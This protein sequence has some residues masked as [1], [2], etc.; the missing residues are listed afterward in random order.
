MLFLEGPRGVGFSYQNKTV[1]PDNTYS[2]EATIKD[3][4]L[5]LKDFFD[6]YPEYQDREFYV[7]AESYGG[8]YGPTLT[9]ALIQEIQNGQFPHLNLVGMG[10]LTFE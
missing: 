2:D 9:R 7:F 8:V 1:D 3:N 4:V 6:T 5:A 10:T